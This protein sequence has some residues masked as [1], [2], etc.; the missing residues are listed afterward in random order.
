MPFLNNVRVKR[1]YTNYNRKEVLPSIYKYILQLSI[2]DI[3]HSY[4][5]NTTIII[6][7]PYST[8][9]LYIRAY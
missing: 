7:T 2:L 8:S 3:I 5:L 4:T 9:S 6:T 1:L